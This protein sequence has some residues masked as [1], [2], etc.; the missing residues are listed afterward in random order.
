MAALESRVITRILEEGMVD[1]IRAGLS[2]D[3]FKDPESRQIFKFIRQHWYKPETIKTVPSLGMIQYRWPSFEPT[4]DSD[5]P[6]VRADTKALINEL[7]VMSFNTDVRSLASFFHELADE[8]PEEAIRVIQKHTT[9]LTKDMKGHEKLGVNEVTELAIEHYEGTMTGAVYG[10]PYPWKCLN[11][12]TMGKHEGDFIVLYGRMKSMKTW[13]LLYMAIYDYL[14]NG[15]RVIIWSREMNKKKMSLRLAALLAKIDYQ[16]FKKGKLPPKV[17]E[18]FYR[19]MREL[20]VEDNSWD[21]GAD[22]EAAKLIK[23]SEEARLGTRSMLLLCGRQAPKT[24]EELRAIIQD[25]CPDSVYLDSFYHMDPA[26]DASNTTVRWQRIAHLAESIKEMAEDEGVPVVASHQANRSGEKTMGET[27]ADM[28]D[29]DVIAREA[30]LIIRILR[31]VGKNLYEEDY[32]VAMEEEK[33]RKAKKLKAKAKRV[34]T[35]LSFQANKKSKVRKV[36][37][38]ALKTTEEFLEEDIPRISAEIAMIMSGNREGTLNGFIIKAIPGY[39]FDVISVNPSRDDIKEWMRD[40]DN[41]GGNN[42]PKASSHQYRS[43]E[44]PKVAAANFGKIGAR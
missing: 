37:Q 42:R 22:R 38:K 39:N 40:I 4:G 2:A 29:S 35:K 34:K 30:D 44:R 9:K 43:K 15:A 31:K 36:P 13:I 32:E 41:D 6:D 11:E 23:L 33:A 16:L 10:L 8:D 25:Y 20:K 5:D 17:R 19:I 27:M 3:M 28:A 26:K 14:V 1:A 12:D 7:K 18:R 21:R 24:V